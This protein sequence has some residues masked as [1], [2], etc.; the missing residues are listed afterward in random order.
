[1]EAGLAQAGCLSNI[2]NANWIGQSAFHKGNGSPHRQFHPIKLIT[3]LGEP[4]QKKRGPGLTERRWKPS[5]RA[6]C[7]YVIDKPLNGGTDREKR[8]HDLIINGPRPNPRRYIQNDEAVF[9]LSRKSMLAPSGYEGRYGSSHT[10]GAAPCF[11]FEYA[12]ARQDHL[13][14]IVPVALYFPGVAP[15]FNRCDVHPLIQF[16]LISQR[17]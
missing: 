10:T 7:F 3:L 6:K 14:E 15:N 9:G 17:V 4:F 12:R 11:D 13:M 5:L 16:D 1:M 8:R 2:M